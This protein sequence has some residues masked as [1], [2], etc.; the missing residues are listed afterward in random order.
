MILQLHSN[1]TPVRTPPM[2]GRRYVEEIGS[3]AMLAGKR[4]AGVTPE[5]NLV[6][7]QH[8]HLQQVRIRLP[9]LA[10]KP[11]GGVTRSTKQG[12]QW[13]QK[14]DLCPPKNLK[15]N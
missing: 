15:Q 2:S 14:K 4:S 12:Y 6:E 5:V 3:A 1:I 7:Q 10:L 8:V 9:T 11:R 13:P